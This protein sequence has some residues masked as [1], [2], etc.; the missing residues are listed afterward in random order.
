MAEPELGVLTRQCLDQ[1]IG[2]L[3]QVSEL[4]QQWTQARNRRQAG[5]DW[6]FRTADARIKLKYLFP[7][8]EK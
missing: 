2:R 5:I 4:A 1:R 6:Q 7:K 8:I 3:V